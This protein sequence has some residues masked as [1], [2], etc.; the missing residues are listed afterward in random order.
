MSAAWSGGCTFDSCIY[1]LLNFLR[2]SFYWHLGKS[3][4]GLHPCFINWLIAERIDWEKWFYAVSL[5]P[6]QSSIASNQHVSTEYPHC[7]LAR[8]VCYTSRICYH[9][10][11]AYWCFA[12]IFCYR[13]FLLWHCWLGVRKSM[14]LSVWSEV[15]IIC[16]WSTWCRCHPN[17]P[18]SLASF[19]SRLE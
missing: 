4:T 18:L 15:Q 7:M 1:L 11:W 3:L 16:I 10:L 2:C 5:I 12:V 9:F 14:W 6:A 8:A 17:A 19:K 13:Y